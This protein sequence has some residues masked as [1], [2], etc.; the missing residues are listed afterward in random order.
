MIAEATQLPFFLDRELV[1]VSVYISTDCGHMGDTSTS[2]IV[3]LRSV[4]RTGLGLVEG[5]CASIDF[6]ICDDESAL[7]AEYLLFV[8]SRNICS[9][10]RAI[11]GWTVDDDVVNA[12][13]V[14]S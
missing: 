9:T 12:H 10:F 6:L 4:A 8:F 3:L 7:L 5:L 2:A 1:A 14:S 13:M 11:L